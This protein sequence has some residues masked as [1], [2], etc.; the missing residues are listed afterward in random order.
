[1]WRTRFAR[2]R[3]ALPILLTTLSLTACSNA[4]PPVA[5]PMLQVERVTVPA[6]LLVPIDRPDLPPRSTPASTC[7]TQLRAT[8]DT[9]T[10]YDGALARCNARFDEIRELQA[11]P[12]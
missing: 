2:P 1:M 8:L 4:P 9:L 3:L 6:P 12:P 11:S 5:V 7:Y 10:R